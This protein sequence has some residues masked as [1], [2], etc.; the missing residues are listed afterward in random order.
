MGECCGKIDN[1]NIFYRKIL[2]VILFINAGMFFIEVMSSLY[3]DSQSLLAD[4]LDFLGDAINYGVSLYVLNK[5]INTR[6]KASIIKGVTMG[7][8][9]FWVVFT[10]VLKVF[11]TGMP[12]ASIMGLIGFLALLA[13]VFSAILLYKYR[14]GDS[15]KAS[16]WICS[17]NDALGNI[18][19]MAAAG[20][21]FAT[22]S[23][24][25]DLLVAVLI[26]GLALSGS[27]HI[28]KKAKSELAS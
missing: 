18:A 13:N 10:T 1:E 20:G 4:S 28:L 21:V 12:Q 24:W 27:W 17:R 3:S 22:S 2:W 11:V 14:S 8:F 5:S 7:V 19:V 26:A 6:A 23:R 16:V 9:G 25:P 15:N